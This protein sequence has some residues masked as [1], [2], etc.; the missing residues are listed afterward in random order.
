[1]ILQELV[2]QNPK[3]NLLFEAAIS[4]LS[5]K[6]EACRDFLT[7]PWRGL[8]PSHPFIKMLDQVIENR[9]DPDF[10]KEEESG[11]DAATEG[12]KLYRKN[13]ESCHGPGGKGIENLA[14]PLYHSEYLEGDP[15]K[16][17][18]LTLHGLKGPIHVNGKRYELSAVMPG[19][20]DNPDLTD[21]DIAAILKFIRN[22]FG[23]EPIEIQ[24]EDVAKLRDVL[25]VDG[26]F[27]EKELLEHR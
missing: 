14:P 16:L 4:G 7:A 24:P 18:L 22:G 9:N 12:L 19:V 5:G 26:M 1:M 2:E 6:E 17:I 8:Q 20:K 10:L 15:K 13:C 27:T 21:Q 3:D 11:F 25:P 23:K